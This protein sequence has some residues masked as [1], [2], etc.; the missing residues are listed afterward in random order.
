MTPFLICVQG[1]EKKKKKKE[2]ERKKENKKIGEE[3]KE[4]SC[5]LTICDTGS[6]V[7]SLLSQ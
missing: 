6:R 4:T 5:K 1:K 7:S 2:E 3:R